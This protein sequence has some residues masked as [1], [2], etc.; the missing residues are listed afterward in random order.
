VSPPLAVAAD[1]YGATTAD[2]KALGAFES[3]VYEFVGPHGPSILKVI[4]PEHRTVD[5]VQA[6]VDWLL[7][8]REG[9]LRVAEPI[10]SRNGKWVETSSAGPDHKVLVAFRRAAGRVTAPPDWTDAR[11]TAW[12]EMLGH[13]QD[14]SRGWNPPG[15]RRKHLAEKINLTG[16]SEV[17]PDDPAFVAAAEVLAGEAGPLLRNGAD[18]GLIHADLHHWNLLLAGEEWTAIDFDDSAY[19]PYAFDLAMPLFYAVRSPREGTPDTIAEWFLGPFLS[20][21]TRRTSLPV[22]TAEELS[23]YLRFREL[24]LVMALRLKLP[25]EKWTK[26]LRETEVKLR[27]NV[28]EGREVVSSALLR[29]W[30]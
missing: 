16:F 7:A 19:G 11:I 22:T 3:D 12:G 13:L 21:F 17:V 15:P 1:L 8:L 18:S 6:E 4:A 26:S 28:A 2:F 23:L 20:G 14:H 5:E 30:F 9:G 24:D 29:R 27:R 25:D 10:A